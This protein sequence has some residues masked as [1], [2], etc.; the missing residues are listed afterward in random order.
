[1][2]MSLIRLILKEP[3][4]D[5]KYFPLTFCMTGSLAWETNHAIGPS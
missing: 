5:A 3:N 2:G 1:M 4:E